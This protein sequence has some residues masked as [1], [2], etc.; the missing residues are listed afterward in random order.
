MAQGPPAASPSDWRV[1]VRFQFA[2]VVAV[3]GLLLALFAGRAELAVLTVPWMVVL[4]LGLFSTRRP[5]FDVEVEPRYERVAAGQTLEVLYRIRVGADG[6]SGVGAPPGLLTMSWPRSVAA[7]IARPVVAGQ[8]VEVEAPLSFTQWGTYDVGRVALEFTERFGLFR[9]STVVHLPTPVRVHPDEMQLRQLLAPRR[10][11]PLAGAHQSPVQDRGLEFAG[12]RPH[13]PG[14]SMREVNWRA[15]ARSGD[16]RVSQRHPDRSTDVVLL[17]D[18]FP[19]SYNWS[20][21]DWSDPDPDAGP[22]PVDLL[23][24]VVRVAMAVA[25]RYLSVVDRVGLVEVGGIIRWVSPAAGRLQL[26]RLIDAALSIQPF[27]N[28]ARRDLSVVPRRAIP[29]TALVVVVSPL[30]DERFVD[31]IIELAGRGHDTAV[32]MLDQRQHQP[33]LDPAVDDDESAGRASVAERLWAAEQIMVRDRLA[34][35]G[36]AVAL[37]ERDLGLSAAGLQAVLGELSRRRRVGW[38]RGVGAR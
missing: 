5:R 2:V 29:P 38:N 8:P 3:V 17:I 18:T 25:G 15:T 28:W 35:H 9:W 20:D 34:Q 11:H 27:Q 19:D 16:L 24:V 12:V 31:S 10:M 30:I 22:A 6:Q 26:Y 36:V 23:S 4:A 14:D 32:V 37:W 21:R 33:S 1:T 13:Q 7:P